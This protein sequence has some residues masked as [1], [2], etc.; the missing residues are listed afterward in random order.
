MKCWQGW[1]GSRDEQRTGVHDV[2]YVVRIQH[3]AA[4]GDG[5]QLWLR[6]I[7][8]TKSRFSPKWGEI[9]QPRARQPWVVTHKIRIAL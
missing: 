5:N 2:R 3:K 1:R 4:N 9:R 6:I 7:S 8:A